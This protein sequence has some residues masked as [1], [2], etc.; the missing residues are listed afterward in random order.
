MEGSQARFRL[1]RRQVVG[2][3]SAAAI[4]GSTSRLLVSA[5]DGT[6]APSGEWSFT[7]DKGVTVTL[8]NAPKNVLMDVNV[9]AP[10]WDF[11]IRPAGLFGW[12]VL[13]DGTLGDAGGNIDPEGIPT[14][15]DVNEPI[16]VE[17]AI[18]VEPDLIITLSWTLD[19]P[20]DY[21]S[22]DGSVLD[23]VKAVA[24]IIALSATGIADKNTERFAELAGLLGADLDSPELVAAK[25]DYNEADEQFTQLAGE[26]SDLQVLFLAVTEET[27]WVA[28]PQDWADLN[29]YQDRGL[30]IIVPD[31]E[32]GAFWQQ[33]SNEQALL[34]PADMFFQ[35]TRDEALTLEEIAAH[36]SWSKHP[37]VQAGQAFGWNQDFIQSYQ[38]LKA[39]LDALSEALDASEKIL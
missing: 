15:G 31:V 4:A 25:A 30:N 9:A 12:N 14:A 36:P 13:A 38:G 26:K 2:T 22:I 39:A 7:D 19:D 23:Q 28:N 1:S 35:S 17:D 34:Y 16:R 10:L 20:N 27:T 11:G 29:M 6:P 21:W 18:A 33:I 3:L 37:A 24:P 5:Q 32:P 8:P